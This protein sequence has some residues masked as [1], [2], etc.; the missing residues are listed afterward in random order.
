VPDARQRQDYWLNEAG[1]WGRRAL[2]IDIQLRATHCSAA[3]AAAAAVTYLLHPVRPASRRLTASPSPLRCASSIAAVDRVGSAKQD[4]R[5][6]AVLIRRGCRLASERSLAEQDFSNLAQVE[7]RR[8]PVLEARQ[9]FRRYDLR[10]QRRT[11]YFVSGGA[12]VGT[13][14]G[15]WCVAPRWSPAAETLG[16]GAKPPE[17][18]SLCFRMS[19]GSGKFA[20]FCVFCKLSNRLL[21]KYSCKHDLTR[22]FRWEDSG[23]SPWL[24]A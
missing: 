15:V 24:V 8:L 1:I 17:T 6:T 20:S 19:D 3:L 2:V 12:W 4:L 22:D 13:Y 7:L 21:L 18:E 23:F 5:H 14:N 9:F 16:L 11:Y 10:H